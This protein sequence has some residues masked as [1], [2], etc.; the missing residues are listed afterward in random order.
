MVR[1]QLEV[2]NLQA[3]LRNRRFVVGVAHSEW[4][5]TVKAAPLHEFTE[6]I[7]GTARVGNWSDADN[8]QVAV[9]TLTDAARAFYNGTLE[10]HDR[11]ITWAICKATSQNQFRDVRTD[12]YHFTQTQMARQ[13]RRGAT[14]IRGSMQD[15]ST[16]NHTAGGGFGDAKTL[17]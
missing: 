6:A 13:K 15:F 10:Q 5:G 2:Q 1:L 11:S 4:A 7:E 16:K 8:V 17:S 3:Q 14:G 12:E 9:M